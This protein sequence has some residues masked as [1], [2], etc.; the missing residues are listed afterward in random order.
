MHRGSRATD[1]ISLSTRQR[2]LSWSHG[3]GSAPLSHP[4]D[5]HLA[6]SALDGWPML[7]VS[8]W[9]RDIAGRNTICELS[10][11]RF[12]LGYCPMHARAK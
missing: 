5:V 6:T 2:E 9:T 10:S 7:A 8:A 4:I 12:L 1:P 11:G 3:A